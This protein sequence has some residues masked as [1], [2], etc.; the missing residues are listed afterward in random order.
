MLL[1][2]SGVEAVQEPLPQWAIDAFA[3]I[4]VLGDPLF[5]IVLVSLVYWLTDQG[6]AI[7][8][9]AV[10][11]LAFGLTAGLKEAFAVERPPAELQHASEAGFGIPSGHAA[12]AAAV[13]GALAALYD[14]GSR[15]L[16]YATAAV[17]VGLV[18]VSRIVLGVH[19]LADVI[20]GLALG[21]AAVALVVRYRDRSP[22]PFF[23]V[24][25]VAALFGAWRSGFTYDQALLLFG[26][27][28]AALG[29]WFVLRPLPRPPRRVM[30]ACSAAALPLVV[31]L[32]AL[33][34]FVLDSPVG[35]VASTG[36]A[37]AVVLVTPHAGAAVARR[38]DG[39]TGQARA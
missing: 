30:A 4:T 7:R 9:V 38:L 17:L 22:A 24:G 11:L 21:L 15:R 2:D 36:L 14:V 29:C 39:P 19:Y 25:G 35:L 26:G 33:G 28:V 34:L 20:A 23:A 18:S 32:S 6:T 5:F 31:A 27:A 37:M 10:L 16:R 12:G 13:Y 3:A 1:A 8:V